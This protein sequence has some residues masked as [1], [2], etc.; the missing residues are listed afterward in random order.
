MAVLAGSRSVL[1]V[2]LTL[3]IA[4]AGCATIDSAERAITGKK[5]ETFY[6]ASAGLPVRAAAFVTSKTISRLALHEKVTRTEV[7]RGFAHIVTE[8]GVEGWVD[9]AQLLWRLPSA[10]PATPDS[11]QPPKADEEPLAP[12][13]PAPVADPEPDPAATSATEAAE[14]APVPEPDPPPAPKKKPPATYDPF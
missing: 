7:D 9:N 4:V 3:A 1:V 12:A 5:S 14:P 11:K 13:E 6:S 10:A 8:K 2:A